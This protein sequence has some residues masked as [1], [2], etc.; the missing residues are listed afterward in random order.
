MRK[1][2]SSSDR[3]AYEL[4]D[5]ARLGWTRLHRRT[6]RYYK[7]LARRALRRTLAHRLRE[8]GE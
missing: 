8:V 2:V 7:R 4:L 6:K 3:T 1:P 5:E